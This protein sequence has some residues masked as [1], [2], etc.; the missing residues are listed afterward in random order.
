[1][2][3]DI[4]EE[5]LAEGAVQAGQQGLPYEEGLLLLAKACCAQRAG[6]T[7]EADEVA[8]GRELLTR[9][10]VHLEGAARYVLT[11]T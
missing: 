4:F 8:R 6:R 11:P 7:A 1:M 9:C 3:E 5:L 2:F 10:G